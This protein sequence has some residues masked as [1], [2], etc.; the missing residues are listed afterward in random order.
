MLKKLTVENFTVFGTA[1]FEF[2]MLNVIHGVNGTGKTHL[3]KV[4]YGLVAGIREAYEGTTPEHFAQFPV[5]MPNSHKFGDALQAVFKCTTPDGLVRKGKEQAKVAARFG[6]GEMVDFS[7]RRGTNQSGLEVTPSLLS[8]QEP[9][10]IPAYNVMYL[11]PSFALHFKEYYTDFER[12]THD[13]VKQ[14][15]APRPKKVDERMGAVEAALCAETGIDVE[16]R[17]DDVFIVKF[18][19]VDAEAWMAAEGHRR[20][21]T[22]LTLIRNGKVAPGVQMFWDEPEANI[23][24][25]LLRQ[26]AR[27]LVGLSTAGV[28]VFVA[29]HS[30]F[31]IREFDILLERRGRDLQARYF[32]LHPKEKGVQV[33]QGDTI[34]DAGP[35]AALDENLEQSERFLAAGE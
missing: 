2:G 30:L 1:E 25:A 15:Y 9:V 14:L 28:Q 23:N 31:L 29:T 27:A 17:E 26:V 10:F 32:G 8:V 20:L 11:R 21:A 16:L 12:V 33:M 35:I 3:L 13:I 7:L 24:P 34:D 6:K 18:S 22:L 5:R 4:V 19:G